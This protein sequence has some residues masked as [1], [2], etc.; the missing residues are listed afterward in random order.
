MV[1]QPVTV[2]DKN[3]KPEVK[4]ALYYNGNYYGVDKKEMEIGAEFH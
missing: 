4:D 1:R 3:G 2:F